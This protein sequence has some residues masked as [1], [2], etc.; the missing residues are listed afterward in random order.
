MKGL[1]TLIQMVSAETRQDV[2]KLVSEEVSCRKPSIADVFGEYWKLLRYLGWINDKRDCAKQ[3]Y[4][5]YYR[6][7]IHG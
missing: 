1:E 7:F 4:I 2:K 5:S 6:F 3:P